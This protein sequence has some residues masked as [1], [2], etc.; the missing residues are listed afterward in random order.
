MQLADGGDL[1]RHAIERRLIELTLRV[2]LLRLG[3]RTIKV[4]DH[5]G[6]RNEISGVDLGLIFLR[7][8]RP[9]GALHPRAAAQGAERFV[10]YL[11]LGQLAHSNRRHLGC[12]HLQDHLVLDEADDEKLQAEPG[13]LLHLDAN[14]LAD[15]MRGINDKLA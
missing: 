14:D 8:A 3:I 1:A 5:L 10:D 2:R 15:A 9:H 4:A 13:D 6:D 7:A 11:Q 12:W